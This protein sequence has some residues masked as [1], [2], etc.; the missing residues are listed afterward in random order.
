MNGTVMIETI[1]ATENTI[2]ASLNRHGKRLVQ[3]LVFSKID[4]VFTSCSI[5]AKEFLSGS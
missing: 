5:A 3:C 4:I 2:I 1:T